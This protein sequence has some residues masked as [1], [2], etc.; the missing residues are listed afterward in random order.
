LT[1]ATDFT[2]ASGY[3]T[4]LRSWVEAQNPVYGDAIGLVG[5]FDDKAWTPFR[6]TI[7]VINTEDQDVDL[8]EILY[9]VNHYIISVLPEAMR[10]VIPSLDEINTNNV[11][12]ILVEA[13]IIHWETELGE[14]F[15]PFRYLEALLRAIAAGDPAA[16]EA[17]M[18]DAEPIPLVLGNAGMTREVTS[19]S[20]QLVF[21]WIRDNDAY[22]INYF[23]ARASGLGSMI[24]A[25][26]VSAIS[27]LVA[28]SM[29]P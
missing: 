26:D 27:Q 8:D 21:N 4:I 28:E 9:D 13:E 12:G 3:L 24:N 25:E 7:Y 15:V 14:Y 10:D 17:A 18:I 22:P 20:A 29:I 5:K 1:L 2:F 23:A 11:V 16:I 6:L 19:N